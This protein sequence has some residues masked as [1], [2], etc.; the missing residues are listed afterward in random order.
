MRQ[1]RLRGE[2]LSYYHC[3]SRVVDRRYIFQEEEKE[4]FVG[5]MRKLEAFLGLRVVT[6]C[7]MSNHFHLL[8]EEPDA[9]EVRKLDREALLDRARH[10]YNEASIR[11]LTEEFDRAEQSGSKLWEE[12]ILERYRR[13]MGDV[14]IFIKELKQRFTQSY[15]RRK[16][17][18]GTLWEDRY[19]SVLVEGDPKALMTMAAYIDLNPVRA[20]MVNAV[21]DYRWCGYAS[22]VGGNRWA[23]EGLGRILNQSYLVSG[24]EFDR[25]WQRTS[26]VYRLWLYDQGK[27]VEKTEGG[28]PGHAKR[29]FSPGD[30]E[31]E[32][33]RSGKLSLSEVIRYRVR[34]LTDGAVFGSA[35]FVDEVFHRYR[36]Q[37]G[38]KR[39]S[40]A[41]RMKDAAWEDLCVLRDL[42]GSRV[43]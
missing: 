30:V 20:G 8:V 18:R 28:N 23:K 27:A 34:Y 22:A 31:R 33:D 2:G 36:D 10:L 1:A 40:G 26:K 41:R 6:Y 24:E 12:E 38:E 7:I 19:K 16:G 3:I 11:D 13:R 14:S 9:E 25:N 42:R 32:I 35:A 43:G 17:R 37:F 4:L 29:G 39:R 21:E 15:N 5:I